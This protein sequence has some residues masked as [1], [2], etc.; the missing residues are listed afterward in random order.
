MKSLKPI[1]F[2]LAFAL[3]PSTIWAITAQGGKPST[4]SVG[5]AASGANTDITSLTGTVTNDSAAA[6][7]WGEYISSTTASGS[8]ATSGQFGN[9]GQISL[10]A[11][12]WDVSAVCE[13]GANGAT[14]TLSQ[15]AISVNSGNTTTDHVAGDNQISL[16]VAI[17]TNGT[18][19]SIA[20][21]RQSLTATTI[22]YVK[23]K[24]TFS[25]ATPTRS[26]R[27]SGRRAR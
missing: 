18:G 26:C 10:T 6:G 21:Y 7:K 11:G 16:P 25:I 27:I 15:M 8:V 2:L 13:I 5:A 1:L 22:V 24:S 3:S 19:G 14:V 9:A 4:S 12:D 17:A 20:S 23:V